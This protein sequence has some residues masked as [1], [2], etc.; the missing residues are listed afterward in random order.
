M[1]VY[2]PLRRLHARSAFGHVDNLWLRLARCML[3]DGATC[4]S[5]CTIC[6]KVCCP[7]SIAFFLTLCKIN[8]VFCYRRSQKWRIPCFKVRQRV[9]LTKLSILAT[10]CFLEWSLHAQV[11]TNSVRSSGKPNCTL[12]VGSAFL[13]ACD[14][15]NCHVMSQV[16]NICISLELWRANA[17]FGRTLCF[18]TMC[19]IFFGQN[20]HLYWPYP[21]HGSTWVKWAI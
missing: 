16:T 8:S 17:G 14:V 10:C 21:L 11:C 5:C 19:S 9:V 6:W 7:I 4:V 15:H 3:Q 2:L 1:P 18:T 12:C 20:Y 13:V